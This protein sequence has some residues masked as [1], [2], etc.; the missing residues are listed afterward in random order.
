MILRTRLLFGLLISDQALRKVF[1]K[2]IIENESGLGQET[3][4]EFKYIPDFSKSTQ[5][6]DAPSTGIKGKGIEQRN[7]QALVIGCSLIGVVGYFGAKVVIGA[8]KRGL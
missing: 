4:F 7:L 2:V 1:W 6:E 3:T 5:M 8:V